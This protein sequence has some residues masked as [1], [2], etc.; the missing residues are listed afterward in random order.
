MAL[1]GR[2]TRC[3]RQSRVAGVQFVNAGHLLPGGAHFERIRNDAGCIA[4]NYARNRK[5]RASEFMDR[6]GYCIASADKRRA[7]LTLLEF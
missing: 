7:L 2:S 1:T 3:P 4:W 5:G 6:L